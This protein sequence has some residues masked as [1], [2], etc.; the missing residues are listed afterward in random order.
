MTCKRHIVVVDDE[1]N[2]G[3]SLRLIV[4]GEG[5]IVTVCGSVA[6][7]QEHRTTGRAD[8][9]LFDLRLP[10]GTGVELLRSLRQSDDQ[11]PAIMISG[12]GTIRDAVDATRIGAFDF[13]E[14]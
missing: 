5:Y 4:E 8:L 1:A 10:D 11:T 9:Y 2:I 14:K 12:H 3:S 13:L 7:F 6:R